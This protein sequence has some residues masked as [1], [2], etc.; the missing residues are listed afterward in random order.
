MNLS[1]SDSGDDAFG[2]AV[3]ER[4]ELRALIGAVAAS[5]VAFEDPRLDYIEV[6]IDRTTWEALKDAR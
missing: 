4:D 2:A 1:R 5:G 3:R 6:Q